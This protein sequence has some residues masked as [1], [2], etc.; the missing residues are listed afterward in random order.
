M[1]LAN[2]R[3]AQ[4]GD[5]EASNYNDN[6]TPSSLVTLVLLPALLL[7][8]VLLARVLLFLLPLVP[9]LVLL[10]VLLVYTCLKAT[11]T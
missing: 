2:Q 3:K 8:L 6:I 10:H 11:A 9:L 5:P 1:R 4:S 7:A